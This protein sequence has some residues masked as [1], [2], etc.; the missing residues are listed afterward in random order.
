[1]DGLIDTRF[2]LVRHAPVVG[3]HGRCYGTKDVDCDTSNEAAFHGLARIVP[4][5]GAWA[6]T[7][8]TR[9]KRTAAAIWA[10]KSKAAPVMPVAHDMIEQC[11]GDWQGRTYA[12]IGAYGHG[13]PATTHRHWLSMA[14]IKPAG[15]ESFAEVC[16]RVAAAMDALAEVH[17]GQ[18]VTVVC[19]GGTIRAA[20]AYALALPAET[21][22]ALV[23]D[24]LSVTRLDRLDG[25]GIGHSWRVGFV[26]RPP[27]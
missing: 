10:A 14:D 18:D 27:V 12:E 19:H 11:F 5:G 22:L 13:D 21:A 9:T 6:T 20:V 1:M 4:D 17:R 2:W 26:N 15:G 23:I 7:S 3:Q 8:L 24:T 16:V 25:S